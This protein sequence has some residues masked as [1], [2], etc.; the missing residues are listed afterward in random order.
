MGV[1]FHRFLRKDRQHLRPGVGAKEKTSMSLL[2]FA[3]RNFGRLP[4]PL[5]WMAAQLPF[6]AR[7]GLAGVYNARRRDIAS[8]PPPGGLGEISLMDLEG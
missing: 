3:K 6:G 1:C 7:P 8:V 5:G 4:Y 2:L